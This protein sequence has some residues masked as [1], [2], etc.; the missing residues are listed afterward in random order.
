[1][2][3]L[4]DKPIYSTSDISHISGQPTSYI[5]NRLKNRHLWSNDELWSKGEITLKINNQVV[6]S[7]RDFI[8]LEID[9]FLNEKK[10]SVLSRKTALKALSEN[11]DFFVDKSYIIQTDGRDVYANNKA[12]SHKNSL[13]NVADPQMTSRPIL[14]PILSEKRFKIENRVFSDKSESRIAEWRPDPNY[15]DILIHPAIAFGK[16]YI[17]DYHIKTEILFRIWQA[18]K[19]EYDDLAWEYCIEPDDV[20]LIEQAIEFEKK[21]HEIRQ[22]TLH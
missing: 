15:P 2:L 3:S 16:P 12:I 14:E 18:R 4:L 11:D 22:C 13:S 10:V 1:M 8:F 7:Y 20:N 6:A 17:R 5:R 9:R 21:L 19:P